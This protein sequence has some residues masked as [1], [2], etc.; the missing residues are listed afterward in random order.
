MIPT[1]R[2]SKFLVRLS[3]FPVAK[4]FTLIKRLSRNYVNTP[5]GRIP[6]ILDADPEYIRSILSDLCRSKSLRLF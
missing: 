4:D 2:K 6:L 3:Y 5:F 1:E